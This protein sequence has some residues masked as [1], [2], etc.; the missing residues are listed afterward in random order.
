M[1]ETLIPWPLQSASLAIL[2]KLRDEDAKSLWREITGSLCKKKIKL[3]ALISEIKDWWA[4]QGP[5]LEEVEKMLAADANGM[6]SV[7]VFDRFC[8]EEDTYTY[9]THT[10]KH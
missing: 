7:E 9:H 5:A 10:K 1:Y 2:R 4:V 3:R 6:V 8:G